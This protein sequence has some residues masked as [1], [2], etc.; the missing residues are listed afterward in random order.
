MTRPISLSLAL[1]LSCLLPSLAPAQD[2]GIPLPFTARGNEPFWSLTIAAEGITYQ[3]MEGATATAPYTAPLEHKD[4]TLLYDT[5]AGPLGLSRGLCH[6]DMS[7]MA[8]PYS[9]TLTRSDTILSGCAGDPAT[10]LAG[11]W[12]ATTLNGAPL[13]DGTSVTLSFLDGR[14]LGNSGCNRLIG[15]YTLTGE[16]L[17]L[18]N[19]GA[20]KMACPAPQ[21]E[22]EQAVFSALAAIT[23]FDIAEDGALLLKSDEAT[24]LLTATR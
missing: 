11:D 20:T 4:G 8:Y 18:G 12:T 13:P 2:A 19:I 14:I 15:S 16:G 24:T 21:M 23:Q 9:V 1:C 22:T 7:G 17:T 6:D 5:P 3:D 10:L